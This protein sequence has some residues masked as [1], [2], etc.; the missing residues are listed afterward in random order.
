MVNQGY[1]NHVVLVLDA[2]SS[3]GH[4]QKE[5]VAVADNLTKY[6]SQRSVELDQETRITVYKFNDN[7][8][9][10]YYDKDVLR[11]PS[12]GSLYRTNGMTALLDATGQAI[13]DLEKTATLYGDHAFLVYILTDG[14]E[15]ASRL[16]SRR[17]SAKLSSLPDNWTVA[18][19]V[20]DQSGI[21]EAKKFGFPPSNISLWDVS[22]KGISEA[23]EA[24]RK[25]TDT[26]MQARAQGVRGSKS[27]FTLSLDNIDKNLLTKLS[28]LRYSLFYNDGDVIQIKDFVE[29]R[30]RTY[31]LGQGYYELVKKETVQPLKDVAIM[32]KDSKDI[33]VGTEARRMLGLPSDYIMIAPQDH[34]RYDIFIQSTSVNRKVMPRQKV[35]YI[36][37]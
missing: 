25:A 16:W 21:F 18:L 8:E 37:G 4:L 15:N 35:L 6:L 26:F 5:V 11:L 34:P 12:M 33:Y 30:G 22:P 1:I 27:I 36:H 19:M 29:N 2:S 7:V 17:I 3:M 32:E 10:L 13:E 31:R 9:C 24:I 20:P 23:G 28:P 14:Q